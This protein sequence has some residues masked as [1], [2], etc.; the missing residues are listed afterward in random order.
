MAKFMATYWF[1]HI[2]C[3]YSALIMHTQIQNDCKLHVKN[4]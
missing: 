1:L 3:I 4:M 2:F